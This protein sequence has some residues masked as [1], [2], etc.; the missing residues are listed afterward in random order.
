MSHRLDSPGPSHTCLVLSLLRR[1]SLSH[2]AVRE[3]IVKHN[4]V[5]EIVMKQNDG[6][7][8]ALGNVL[9]GLR[10]DTFYIRHDVMI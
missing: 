1:A 6:R 3:P 5:D 10:C 7:I 9:A 4:V 8:N 2:I